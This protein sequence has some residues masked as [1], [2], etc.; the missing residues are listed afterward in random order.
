L[1]SMRSPFVRFQTN[2]ERME[3]KG[4]PAARKSV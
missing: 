2:G 3:S 4:E 1:L